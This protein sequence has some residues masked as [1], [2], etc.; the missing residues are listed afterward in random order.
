VWD[1]RHQN[2]LP[3]PPGAYQARLK[4]GETTVTE[5]F[6]LLIDPNVAAEG[7]TAADLQEHFDHNVRVAAL[8]RDVGSAVTRVNQARQ[9]NAEGTPQRRE[10]DAIAVRLIT[11]PVRYGKPGLQAHITYLRGLTAPNTDMKI[12]RDA[13][14]RYEVL[15]KELDAVVAELNRVIGPP[16]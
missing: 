8:I 7:I 3:A 11:E 14:T 13:I 9:R 16:Q 15:R 5:R 2:D 4:V 1:G 12:G 10:I 6:N